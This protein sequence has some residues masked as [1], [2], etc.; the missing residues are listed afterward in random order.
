M[1]KPIYVRFE[2]S[3]ELQDKAYEIVEVARD[4]GKV[5]KGSN[6][7]TKLVERGEAV[8]VVMAE[9]VQPPEILAHLPLLCEERN[10]AYAYVPSKAELGNASGLEKPTAA[11]AIIDI[12]K[13]KPLLENLNEQ[14]KKLKK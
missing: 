12:G 11:V 10:I 3:K 13:G 2:M 9:D 1:A 14:V 5:K 4:T 7:V 8:L 6:E